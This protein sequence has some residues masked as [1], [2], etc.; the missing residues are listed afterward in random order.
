MV[1]YFGINV[2]ITC[3]QKHTSAYANNRKEKVMSIE[4]ESIEDAFE[5][6]K[7]LRVDWVTVNKIENSLWDTGVA[8]F[9][10]TYFRVAYYNEVNHML[11]IINR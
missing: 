5:F 8:F 3:K 4:A 11:S 2:A 7:A 9:D 6:L 1:F 10:R